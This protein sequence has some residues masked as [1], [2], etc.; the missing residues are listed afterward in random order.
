MNLV[1]WKCFIHLSVKHCIIFQICNDLETRRTFWTS[2]VKIKTHFGSRCLFTNEQLITWNLR[3]ISPGLF[4]TVGM[5]SDSWLCSRP[6]TSETDKT[7]NAGFGFALTFH[8]FFHLN[9]ETVKST[10]MW[11]NYQKQEKRREEYY[12][13]MNI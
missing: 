11:L 7:E 1:D 6:Y 12:R 3:E 9:V 8:T 5:W 2:Q 10:K 13:I 4:H